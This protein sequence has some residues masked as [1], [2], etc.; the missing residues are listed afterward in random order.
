MKTQQKK[1]NL[2]DQKLQTFI[3]EF[4]HQ[5]LSLNKGSM[6]GGYSSIKRKKAKNA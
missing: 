5:S 1:L 4:E 2:A 3:M 6:T